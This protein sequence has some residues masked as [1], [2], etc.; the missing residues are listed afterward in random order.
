MSKIFCADTAVLDRN[1]LVFTIHNQ[2]QLRVDI[3]T[4][5]LF[6]LRFSN[7][8]TWTESA[9]NRYQIYRQLPTQP[10]FTLTNQETTV[11]ITTT[12]A[13]LEIAQDDGRFCLLDNAGNILLR[14]TEAPQIGKGYRY[15]MKLTDDERLYGLGDVSRENIMRR[16]ESY[17]TWVKNVKS[18][19]PIPVIFSS[20]NWGLLLN[21]SWRH[22]FDVG[23]TDP[24]QLI[25]TAAQADADFYLFTGDGF[26]GLLDEYSALTGR[27]ALL[28][29]WAYALT[30]VCNQQVDA[31]K[32]VDEA[33]TFRREDIPCDVIGLEPG[34]MEKNYDFSTNKKWH[35][36]RFFIS[37]WASIGPQTF[38]GALKRLGFK[39]SLWLCCDYDLSNY[40]EQQLVGK[41][42]MNNNQQ[43]QLPPKEDDDDFEK[44]QRFQTT[45][46]K[47]AT[48]SQTLNN[49]SPEKTMETVQPE[50]W[51][52]HLKKFID[53]GT[54]AFKLDGS[55]Q[56]IEH[57]DRAWGNGMNDE[58][59]HN[60]YPL[61][62]GKQMAQGFEEYTGCRAMVYSAG[63]YT[64]IQQY[65]ATWAGDTGGGPKPLAS[66]LNLGFSGH[67]NHSCDMDVFCPSGIHFGFLQTWAQLNNWAYWRQP[68]L[69]EPAALQMFK[70]YARLRYQLLPYLYSTA[71]QAARSGMPVMRAMAM[72]YTDDPAWDQVLSQYMLGD[73]FIV[74]AYTDEL[75][76][77]AGNW[78]D[79]WTGRTLRGP[80][81]TKAEFP[82]NRGGCLL[83]REAAI[84]PCWSVMPHVEQGF[85]TEVTFR[86][87]PG[88]NT[89]S[90]VFYEDDGQSLKYRE[91][92]F[93]TTLL[94]CRPDTIVIHPRQG[95]FDDMPASRTVEMLIRTAIQPDTVMVNGNAT[96][97]WV[98]DEAD[99]TIK[100][101]LGS[102][103]CQ[104]KLSVTWKFTQTNKF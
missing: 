20:R 69:L 23:K 30:Y 93:T 100:L 31:F 62:Y 5:R 9:L 66:M 75:R 99:T 11:A 73:F 59:M 50:P 51:F 47:A 102:C 26:A 92:Q 22:F 67:S 24:E 87:Y 7:N 29:I 14:Q 45:N 46:T 28:P 86:A 97:D 43:N 88:D 80:L 71:A 18:Y 52:A 56:V 101:S 13:K 82:P 84:I 37:K 68:W 76:L 1:S 25:C 77:P 91:G 94:E 40:E 34:W 55:N 81:V 42:T 70:D 103:P 89:A 78:I 35:P 15:A 32:L 61:I 6:R 96:C 2:L 49:E 60:L 57:P 74:T 65:V 58:Q 79:F 16:G 98:W 44:D 36:E 41:T 17:E 38:I 83:I 95:A 63:G 4:P 10:E 33:S 21:T 54:C 48:S 64:G 19:I 27:P 90:F 53:Q 12:A 39:L 8:G 85:A 3:L 72:V 104:Q